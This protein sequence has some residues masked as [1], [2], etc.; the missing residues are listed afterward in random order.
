M[1]EG[2]QLQTFYVGAK[3]SPIQIRIYDKGVEIRK[4]GT[5]LWFSVVWGI[6]DFTRVW[7]IEYQLRRPTLKSFR[8]DSPDD[9]LNKSGALWKYL[10]EQWFSLRLPDNETTTRRTVHPFWKDVQA[11]A[12]QFGIPTISLDRDLSTVPADVKTCLSQIKGRIMTFA[13]RTGCNSWEE[14]CE[15]LKIELSLIVNDKQFMDL[16]QTKKIQLGRTTIRHDLEVMED[17]NES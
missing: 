2:D 9:L 16:L 8:I 10:T 12:H 3:S 15:L 11:V 17:E 13:A 4:Y 1:E 6:E 7:R 5:K 14:A